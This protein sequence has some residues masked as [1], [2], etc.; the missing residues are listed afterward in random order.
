MPPTLPRDHRKGKAMAKR[1]RLQPARGITPPAEAK[2]PAPARAS[3]TSMRPPI[4]D[5]AQD[6]A[7]SAAFEEVTRELTN[8]RASGR[9]IQAL[10]L[11][12]VDE[13]YLVRDRIT[14]D[15]NSDDMDALI[16]S[17][18]DRGQQTAIE[19]T[20]LPNG[21]YGLISGWRRLQ[22]LRTLA[23]KHNGVGSVLAIV[24][25]PE[26]MPAAYQA[27]VDENEI[28]A[29][30][31]F[32]ERARIV[33]KARDGGVFN[34]TKGALT[35]LFGAAPRAKRSKINSF[36][37]V[38]DAL[39]AT[40]RFP[41]A[42]TERQGLAM[43]KALETDAGFAQRLKDAAHAN[44]PKDAGEEAEFIAA[45]LAGTTAKPPAPQVAPDK[46]YIREGLTMTVHP[47]GRVVLEGERMS[48]P[49]MIKA[50]RRAL[51]SL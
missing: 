28:R 42:L 8:A 13:T 34:S 45:A 16:E 24:R 3:L 44:S 33:V 50:L 6:A 17:I 47:K 48:E 38:V 29:G 22:A 36:V 25:L 37:A 49:H 10:P 51:D 23:E 15:I 19:V 20:E 35:R 12:A 27:M 14:G 11:E 31:S 43:A 46:I 7:T 26:D 4:A 1:K 40:L 5:V 18:K 32:Y 9:L 21:T 41:T 30:L 39:D 2:A